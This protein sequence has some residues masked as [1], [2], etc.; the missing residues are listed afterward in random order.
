MVP[1]PR[2]T[3][4]DIREMAALK[5]KVDFNDK[6]HAELAKSI[7]K[8][9]STIDELARIV[10]RQD[11][12]SRFSRWFVPIVLSA[13]IIILTSVNAYINN[14]QNQRLSRLENMH[15]QEATPNGK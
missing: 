5:A 6:E 12:A 15:M 13:S 8:L 1:T 4:S 9:T 11:G 14:E 10:N 2:K 3:D 7:E